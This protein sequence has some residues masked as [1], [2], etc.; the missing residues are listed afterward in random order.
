VV[1][2]G[3][4]EGEVTEARWQAQLAAEAGLQRA[5]GRARRR[6]RSAMVG[7]LLNDRLRDL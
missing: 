6:H 1:R 4:G 5:E 2:A 7:L 3:A